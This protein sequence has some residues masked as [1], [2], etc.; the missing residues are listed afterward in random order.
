MS[1]TYRATTPAA[2]AAYADG[3]FEHEFTATEERDA[4]DS[5]L[6]EIVPRTYLVLSNNYSAAGQ[7]ETFEGALLVD[8]EAAL[9]LGGHIERVVVPEKKKRN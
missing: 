6:L 2:V 5:G 9:I 3:V 1:N 8:N 4:L 7:G